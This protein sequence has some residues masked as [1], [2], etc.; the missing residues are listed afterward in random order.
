M[1]QGGGTELSNDEKRAHLSD[2]R[3]EH[4][5]DDICMVE[6]LPQEGQ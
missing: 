1:T 3:R 2:I 5:V 6:V 4:L